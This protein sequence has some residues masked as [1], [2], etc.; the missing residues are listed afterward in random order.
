MPRARKW[1][2]ACAAVALA[3][4]SV[5]GAIL[6]ADVYLHSRVQNVGAVNVWGYRGPTVGRKQPMPSRFSVEP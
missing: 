6:A 4:A 5:G 1:L 2:F 3:T